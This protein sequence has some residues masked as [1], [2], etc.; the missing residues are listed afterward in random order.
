MIT[1][2]PLTDTERATYEWQIWIDSVGETGQEKLKGASVLISRIGGVGEWPP[3]V[4]A[5]F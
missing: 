1:P 2:Q 4:H 3:V 5:I